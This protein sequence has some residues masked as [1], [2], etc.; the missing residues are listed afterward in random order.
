MNNKCHPLLFISAF[1]DIIG[2]VARI[3]ILGA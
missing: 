2:D 3:F 1:K